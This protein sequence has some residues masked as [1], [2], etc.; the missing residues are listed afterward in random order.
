MNR[1]AARAGLKGFEM[2]KAI[3]L[4]AEMF[5]VDNGILTPTFKLKRSNARD[6]FRAQIDDMYDSI[7]NKLK[8]RL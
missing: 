4:N 8:S 5:S 6:V 3:V 2:V 1:Y 7:A